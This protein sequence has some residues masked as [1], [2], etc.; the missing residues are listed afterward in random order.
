MGLAGVAVGFVGVAIAATGVRWVLVGRL[1]EAPGAHDGPA[2]PH[3]HGADG[4]RD[5]SR[6]PLTARAVTPLGS[7]RG[8]GALGVRH[9]RGRR[10][11]VRLVAAGIIRDALGVLPVPQ[12]YAR[13]AG[14]WLL[15]NPGGRRTGGGSSRLR[16][17]TPAAGTGRIPAR[18]YHPSRF[19]ASSLYQVV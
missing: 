14:R 11:A 18:A 6:Q 19:I 13:R 9:G 15:L 2:V 4:S 3:R 7:A 17:I 16:P 12:R 5:G 8:P 10:R 1:L